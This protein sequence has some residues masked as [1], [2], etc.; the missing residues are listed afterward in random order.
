MRIMQNIHG[1]MSKRKVRI[2]CFYY[3]TCVFQPLSGNNYVLSFRIWHKKR[4]KYEKSFVDKTINVEAATLSQCWNHNVST[5]FKYN[6]ISTMFQSWCVTIVLALIQRCCACWVQCYAE[7]SRNARLP[8]RSYYLSVS[9]IL[10]HWVSRWQ[11]MNLLTLNVCC[12]HSI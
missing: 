4:N 7:R 11:F 1:H 12:N 9:A 8:P 2:V 10:F 3:F 5:T 6:H